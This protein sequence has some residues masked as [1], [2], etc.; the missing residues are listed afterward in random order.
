MKKYFFIF[1][2]TL[3]LGCSEEQVVKPIVKTKNFPVNPTVVA[4]N[5]EIAGRPFNVETGKDNWKGVGSRDWSSDNG[6]PKY[7]RHNATLLGGDGAIKSTAFAMSA[8]YMTIIDADDLTFKFEKTYNYPALLN[9]FKKGKQVF[10][11]Y[12]GTN[13]G[14][15]LYFSYVDLN[16]RPSSFGYSTMGNQD[17]SKLEIV[18]VEEVYG[19]G[20]YVTY[21]IDCNIYA[22]V[23]GKPERLV[24]TIQQG[25]R[26]IPFPDLN[27]T[28]G[29]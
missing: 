24:G 10:R 12:T 4:M 22:S 11:N 2:A 3:L 17:G 29:G 5:I 16:N 1:L 21:E 18:K 13:I 19:N 9:H 26:Y 23:G 14:Y 28:P 7:I 20:I 27:P 25:Y 8:P 6:I 15:D